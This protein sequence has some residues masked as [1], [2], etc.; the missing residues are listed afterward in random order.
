MSA[1]GYLQLHAYASNAQ[2]P[3]GDTAIVITDE[4]DIAI[5]MR[6]TDR[7]GLIRPIEIQ[8]PDLVESQS[9]GAS[10]NPYATVNIY[11][12]QNG[13][14][15]IYAEKVQIFAGTTTYQDLEM[16]PLSQTTDPF[17]DGLIYYTP[18]QE[19]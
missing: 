7:N 1:T 13:Y 4:N 10:L 3:L 8:V 6:L 12:H 17:E 9:P 5:A 2:I 19:L 15:P 18:P 11:A 16:I 14:E